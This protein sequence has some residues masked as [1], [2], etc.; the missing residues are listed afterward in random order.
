MRL[1]CRVRGVVGKFRLLFGIEVVEVAEELVEAVRGRQERVL[2]A[3]VVLAELAGGVTQR[4]EQLGDGRVL[5][6]QAD[7]GARQADLG[8]AGADGFWPV[9][10]A[11]RPAVQ[12]CWP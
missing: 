11:A 12:L 10:K 1:E 3:Q 7:V 2:V 5:R 8:Q 9:M 6:L 4:L